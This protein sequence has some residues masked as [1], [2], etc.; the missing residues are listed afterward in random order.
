M[1]AAEYLN[2]FD[3]EPGYLDFARFGPIGRN[4][5]EE[6]AA[7]LP[8][9]AHAR[10]GSLAVLAGHDERMR[11]AAA[12]ASRF[13]A[14]QIVF[15]DSAST[16][17]LQVLFGMRGVLAVPPTASSALAVA[18]QRATAAVEGLS[19]RWID[20]ELG[21][22]TPGTLRGQLDDDV[23][24]V[25]VSLVDPRTG[26]L[27]DLDGVRQVV[28]D[29]LLIVDA[30]HALG[31]ADAPTEFADALVADGSRWMRAGGGRDSSPSAPAP[32]TS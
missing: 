21:L 25:A 32:S 9:V 13:P 28:G 2:G 30:T 31:A 26:H 14:D 5:L 16:A 12:R 22:V 7:H 8:L 29:R 20:S 27:V 11:N 10:F 6:T 4:V 19:V 18:A 23:T 17:V 15:Q 1:D 24:A 3:D